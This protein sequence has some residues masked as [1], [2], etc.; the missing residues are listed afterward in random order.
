MK[1]DPINY[2]RLELNF[3]IHCDNTH[4]I[5]YIANQNPIF[6]LLCI[7]KFNVSD[8][9]HGRT[10]RYNYTKHIYNKIW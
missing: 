8:A 3:K 7:Y 9:M 2:Y 1:C 4:S 10:I 6:L 5:I